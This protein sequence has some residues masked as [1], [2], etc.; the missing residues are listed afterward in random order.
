MGGCQCVRQDSVDEPVG[1]IKKEKPTLKKPRG[2]SSPSMAA[3]SMKSGNQMW[4]TKT[5]RDSDF[6]TRVSN[7]DTAIVTTVNRL[8]TTPLNI[9]ELPD[10]DY[11]TYIFSNINRVRTNPQSILQKIIKGKENITKKVIRD[12]ERWLFVGNKCKVVIKN[13]ESAFD[14]AI[15][16]IEN[17]QPM[18]ALLFKKSICVPVPKTEEEI[19][20]KSYIIEK[21]NEMTARGENVLAFWRDNVFDPETSFIMML[22]DNNIK[23]SGERRGDIF[24]SDYKYIGISCQKINKSFAAYVTFSK[25]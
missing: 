9:N 15:N 1:E 20:D 18:N 17:V 4:N 23:N 24:N 25:K 11:S 2:A 22:V 7:I 16:F 5:E 12:E 3:S 21:V 13:G 14:E 19:K 8:S 10:D 6:R